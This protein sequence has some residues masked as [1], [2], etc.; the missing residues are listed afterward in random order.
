[1]QSL[2]GISTATLAL[3]LAIFAGTS[4]LLILTLGFLQ[5]ILV[6][7]SLRN[8]PRR[9]AQSILII[10]GLMLSTTIIAA[11]LGIGDTVNHSIKM[12]VFNSLGKT[13][14][15]ITARQLSIYGTREYLPDETWNKLQTRALTYNNIDGLMPAVRKT[16]PVTNIRTNRSET[17]MAISAY[18]PSQENNFGPIV[19]CFSR[20]LKEESDYECLDA[21]DNPESYRGWEALSNNISLKS[22]KGREI[23]LNQD[24]AKKLDA[25]EGDVLNLYT[26]GKKTN[27]TVKHV[28]KNGGLAGG[29]DSRPGLIIKLDS[30]QSILDAP[31]KITHILISNKGDAITGLEL[32]NEVTTLVRNLFVDN[33]KAQNMFEQIRSNNTAINMFEEKAKD[34]QETDEAFK[35]KLNSLTNSL[36]NNSF[37]EESISLLSEETFIFRITS[38]LKDPSE[39]EETYLK[40]ISCPGNIKCSYYE[41]RDSLNNLANSILALSPQLSQVRIDE[42]KADGIKLAETIGNSITS[43]FTIFGSFS[44]IVGLLLIF[45]VFVLL[46]AA[47][48]TEMGM[49]RALGLKRLDLIKLFTLEGTAYAVG[50]A[51]IGTVIGIGISFILVKS[52]QNI[53]ET[54]QFSIVPYFSVTSITIAFCAGLL[55]TLLTVILSS[56]RVSKLNIVVAIRGLS[57]EMVQ[58]LPVTFKERLLQFSKALI[59]PYYHFSTN[60]PIKK[61]IIKS[62]INILI[63][64]FKILFLWPKNIFLSLLQIIIAILSKWWTSPFIGIVLIYLGIISSS[65]ALFVIGASIVLIGL[66]LL[67]KWIL[68]KR[69]KLNKENIT[70]I[71]YSFQGLTLVVFWSLPFDAFEF[72]TGELSAGPEVFILGGIGVIVSAVWLIMANTVI[73]EYLITGIIGSFSGLKA[74][75]KTA[76]AYPMASKFRTG[77]TLGMF[78]IVVFNLIIFAVLNN[79][80]DIRSLEPTRI[81]GGFDIS[82]NINP[83]LPIK[84]FEQELKNN[85]LLLSISDFNS[86]S[87]TVS[88]PGK[89]REKSEKGKFRNISIK[90]VDSG[91][92]KENLFQITHYDPQYGT[93][94]RE[95]WNALET[96]KSLAILNGSSLSTDDPFGAGRTDFQATAIKLSDP[97]EIQAFD[98]E[99]QT[100]IGKSPVIN[101]RKI[102]GILDTQADSLTWGGQGATLITHYDFV[103]EVAPFEIP[104]TNYFFKV[105]DEKS[106]ADIVPLLETSFIK[107]SLKALDIKTQIIQ[108]QAQQDS[109]TQLFQAFAGLGLI[110]GI[111]A[112]G[113]ISLRG[114]VERRKHIGMMKAIGFKSYLIQFQF[115][116]E[117]AF[118]TFLGTIIGVIF[119][120]ITSVNI[121]NEISKEVQGLQFSIPW[122]EVAIITSLVIVSAILT[123]ILPARQAS[124]IIPADAL[125]FE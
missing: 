72:L 2:F 124:K 103:K 52:I 41:N 106:T 38:I 111:A 71:V 123:T 110:V 90:S 95:I 87:R 73:L 8:I 40:D 83:E 76:I 61:N 49:S 84:N 58:S 27:L 77:I 66:G 64:P 59:Y 4:I 116:F 31:N 56:Y 23:F 17:R 22:L 48:S 47:R 42:S 80:Q 67:L 78:A 50:A 44:I 20:Y 122:G 102:I 94:S 11:S 91:Y 10:I 39:L 92:L 45:L 15:T 101:T 32:S 74:I 69:T 117:S 53:I 34:N 14:E 3:W 24:A 109:F 25:R 86:Y 36:K 99:L 107:N 18:D 98:I 51:I 105:S 57:E 125:R 12:T 88:L 35:T 97:T 120:I 75:L 13:D 81:T 63:T 46:A 112:I 82:A 100:T 1:M 104:Y 114:V 113:V 93:S 29:G 65:Y 89:A 30:F 118:V 19:N 96:D 6:K 79:L 85:S 121:Y 43:I 7:L 115:L 37:N 26:G 119:G 60:T 16:F 21:G 68:P 54:D 62:I 70:R 28:V 33:E 5:K 55:L 9:T 108:S